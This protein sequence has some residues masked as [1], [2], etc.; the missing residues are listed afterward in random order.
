MDGLLEIILTVLRLL[1][2]VIVWLVMRAYVGLCQAAVGVLY[3]THDPRIILYQRCV[4]VLSVISIAGL[5]YGLFLASFTQHST[6]YLVI[7][8]ACVLMIVT[9]IAGSAVETMAKRVTG[10]A[11]EPDKG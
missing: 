2:Q 4:A 9:G 3:P 5:G 1:V 11:P 7:G 8:A 10:V 6:G